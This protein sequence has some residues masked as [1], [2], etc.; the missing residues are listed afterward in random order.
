MNISFKKRNIISI[1]IFLIGLI[2]FDGYAQLTQITS[3]SANEY[4]PK[5]SP[6]GATL[7]FTKRTDQDVGIWLIPATGGTAEQININKDGDLAFCWSPDGSKIVFDAYPPSGPP[8]DL[9]F[10]DISS[11]NIQQLTNYQG[12]ENHPAWLPDGSR[13]VFTWRGEIWTI[14]AAGG[15]PT[16]ITSFHDDWHPCWSPDGSTIAFTSNRSGHKDI[17]TV[18]VTGGTPTQLTT[19][20]ADDDRACWSP[21]GLKIAFESKR[22]GNADIWILS[23]NDKS[24]KQLTFNNAYDS[25]ADW[26]P[27]G[28]KIAF[29][30]QRNGDL[31]VWVSDVPATNIE[32]KG[33][34]LPENFN[35]Q[36]NFPNPFNSL[37]II[38]FNL[39]YPSQAWIKIFD[40]QGKLVSSLSDGQ[41]WGACL[42]RIIWDGTDN[43]GL[44]K[45]SGEYFLVMRIGALMKAKKMLLIR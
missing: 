31:D 3:S 18:P 5:W 33:Y 29:A 43:N 19:D 32:N 7:A 26:S 6:D 45:S 15:P 34:S 24:L 2:S 28:S 42:H 40:I 37:T 44:V 20:P 9:Y 17:W 11:D 39:S 35:L 16:Q 27:D 25:H 36:Q 21:D 22:S 13:I 30:S 38:Q 1:F 4:H 41:I 10:L 23:L 12:S 14:P 8:A